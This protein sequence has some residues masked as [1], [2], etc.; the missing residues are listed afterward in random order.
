MALAKDSGA[1]GTYR[2]Q[3]LS[4]YYVNQAKQQ[5]ALKAAQQPKSTGTVSQAVV[6]GRAD[7]AKNTN[8]SFTVYNGKTSYAVDNKGN[9]STGTFTNPNPV[10][11]NVTPTT[12]TTTANTDYYTQLMNALMQQN[13]EARQASLDA[14]MQNLEAVKGTYKNQIQSVI[15]EYNNQVNENEVKKAQARRV[16]RENQANRGQLDTGMGKQ[17]QL[18]LNLGYDAI[19]SQLNSAREQA[20]NE[21]YNLIAQAEADANTNR[22]NVN[23]TYN[24]AMLQYQLANM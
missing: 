5:A 16:V 17:E 20:V 7:P 23:N 14:I 24:N 22:A 3:S 13:E 6:A 1:L 9:G 4:D 15:N 21:I 12:T 2:K 18:D 19:T 11:T 10:N 8:N